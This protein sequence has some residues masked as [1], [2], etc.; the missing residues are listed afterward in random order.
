MLL[1]PSRVISQKPRRR[2]GLMI[3]RGARKIDRF[4]T[5]DMRFTSRVRALRLSGDAVITFG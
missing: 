2:S 1:R 3:R 5:A 4:E